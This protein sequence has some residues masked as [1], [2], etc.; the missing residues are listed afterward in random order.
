MDISPIPKFFWYCVGI[1]I[2]VATCTLILIAYR[3]QEVSIEIAHTKIQLSQAIAD[4][5]SAVSEIEQQKIALEQKKTQVKGENQS[6]SPSTLPSSLDERQL[7]KVKES[8][9]QAQ[10]RIITKD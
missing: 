10:Q 7:E 2:L 9:N 3:A 4:M 6:V 5:K 8:L 1:A